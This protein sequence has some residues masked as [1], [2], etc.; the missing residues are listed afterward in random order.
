MSAAFY[1][2]D[3]LR[4]LSDVSILTPQDKHALIHDGTSWVNRE[5]EVPDVLGLGNVLDYFDKSCKLTI[6]SR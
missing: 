3:M 2:P 1:I 4:V 6:T 5:I